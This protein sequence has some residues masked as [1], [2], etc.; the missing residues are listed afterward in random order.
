[1][2]NKNPFELRTD[3]LAMA[4]DYLDRQHDIAMSFGQQAYQ[5]AMES[6]KATAEAWKQFVPEM[7]TME[8]LKKVAED[9]YSFVA[10]STKK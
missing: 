5:A 1:M 7:Y 10:P 3:L 6:N 2:S 8:Q 4:K 9:L